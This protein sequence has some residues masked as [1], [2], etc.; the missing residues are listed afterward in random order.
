MLK[1][2]R[3]LKQSELANTCQAI[4]LAMRSTNENA[5]FEATMC[6]RRSGR[7]LFVT[8]NQETVLIDT[9]LQC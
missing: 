2:F 7:Q 3:E 8:E 6:I 9:P 1:I 5:A 4:A